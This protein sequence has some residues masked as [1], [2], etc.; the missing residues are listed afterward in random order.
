MSTTRFGRAAALIAAFALA[1]TA[2][3]QPA[4]ASEST[5]YVA[6][7]DSFTAGPLI[8]DQTLDVPGCLRS[9]HNYAALLAQTLDVGAFTD[10]SCSGATTADMFAPQGTFWG[11]NA[12]QLDA[13]TAQT[14]LVTIG[15]GGN[16]VGFMDVLV[17]CLTKG[18]LDPLGNPC[19]D[20]FTAGG[21]DELRARIS[22]VATDVA[23]VVEAVHDRAPG[24][25]VVLVGYPA[26]LPPEKGC[27]LKATIAKGDVPYLDGVN[28]EL[29]EMLARVGGDH[30][31][32]FADV[33]DRG[34]SICASR[35]ERWVEAVLPT[36][37][38]APVHPNATG[39]RAV[40]DRL[41]ELLG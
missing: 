38:A 33:Y 10:A 30:D 15:I 7:G 17:T 29:N 27:W 22:D 32:T 34:H 1:A 23:A 9:D 37:P 6:L 39:M 31:A 28:A 3:A 25:E 18:L 40:A 8:P 14:T 16:D 2:F 13:V 20:H 5:V 21:Y 11:T 12:P 19:E 36:R 24:A 4:A 26:L 41:A 35:G